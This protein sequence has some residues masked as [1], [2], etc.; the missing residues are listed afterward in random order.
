[1]TMMLSG[2]PIAGFTIVDMQAREI[3]HKFFFIGK[4]RHVVISKSLHNLVFD[5]NT[6]FPQALQKMDFLFRKDCGSLPKF[7]W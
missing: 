1:M 7:K 5:L 2:V 4:L 6:F 3:Q